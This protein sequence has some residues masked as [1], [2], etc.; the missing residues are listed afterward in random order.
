MEFSLTTIEPPAI[1]PITTNEA[2][3]QSALTNG[4]DDV[5][6]ARMIEQAVG[7]FENATKRRLIEQTVVLGLDR[8]P[9]GVFDLPVGPVSA[10][11]KA[12]VR[13]ATN[14]TT[15]EQTFTEIA[16][17]GLVGMASQRAYWPCSFT[18]WPTIDRGPESLRLTLTCGFGTKPANVPAVIRG[19]LLLLV[20][21]FFENREA[22]IVGTTASELPF[23]VNDVIEHYKIRTYS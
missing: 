3:A 17:P 21:H 23:G 22:T 20:A 10:I 5:Q 8:C 14:A 19:A 13:T 2:R 12:E 9:G 16:R 15:G 18:S 11:T 1:Q 7:Y 4:C 6:L